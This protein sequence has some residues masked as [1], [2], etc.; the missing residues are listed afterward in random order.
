LQEIGAQMQQM[1]P[2]APTR[3]SQPSALKKAVDAVLS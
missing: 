1:R 3:P 2:T